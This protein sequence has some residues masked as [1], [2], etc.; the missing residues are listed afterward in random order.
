[1]NRRAFTLIELLVVIAIIALLVGI[2]LPALGKARASARQMKDA[3]Q[4]RGIQQAC[5]IWAN[6]NQG[7]FPDPGKVDAANTTIDPVVNN[8]PDSK[9]STGHILSLLIYTGGISVELCINPAESNTQSVVQDATYEFDNPQN[10]R[11][12][13]NA[14]WDP[15]FAGTPLDTQYGRTGGANGISNNSYAH[16]LPLGRRK[17]RWQDTFTTTEAVFAD[18]GPTYTSAA[19]DGGTRPTNGRWALFNGPLGTG[20]ATLAIHGSRNSWEGNVAYNDGH[21]T[22]ETR[23]DPDGVTYRRT[24]GNPLTVP[25]NLFVNET[26]EQGGDTGNNLANGRNTYMRPIGSQI[27]SNL[28]FSSAWIWRD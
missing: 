21:V 22:F 7:N 13:D 3:T 1:M 19:S 12:R 17:A 6:Q 5:A 24:S 25:D 28:T 14:L 2:L 10:A 11:D 27:P 16:I 20:S 23:P 18:R 4:V 8:M 15:N 9:N 26:D